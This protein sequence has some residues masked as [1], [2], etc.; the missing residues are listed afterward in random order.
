MILKPEVNS[1]EV[2]FPQRKPLKEHGVY[3]PDYEVSPHPLGK[4]IFAE[5]YFGF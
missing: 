5:V 4:C 3:Q 2:A 1:K